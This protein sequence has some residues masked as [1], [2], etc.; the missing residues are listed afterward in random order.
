MRGFA[1]QVAANTVGSLAAAA[2]VYLLGVVSGHITNVPWATALSIATLASEAIV[3]ALIAYAGVRTEWS[4]RRWRSATSGVRHQN[5]RD[6]ELDDATERLKN[7]EARL[8]RL[9]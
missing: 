7:L 8:E 1:R 4:R 5:S 2:I 3:F 6:P 9:E